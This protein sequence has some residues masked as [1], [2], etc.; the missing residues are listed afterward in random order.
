MKKWYIYEIFNK[1]KDL[2]A[3]TT[4]K[5]LKKPYSYSLAI[6]TGEKVD[7]IELNRKEFY[8]HFPS[9]YKIYTL[10]QIH[11]AKVI[12]VD[13]ITFNEYWNKKLIEADAMVTSQKKIVLSIL[14]ADCTALLAYD[15]I[16]KVIGATHAGWRGT[17]ENIAKNMIDLM[18]KK[19]ANIENIKVAISPSI[20]ACC[21]EVGEEVAKNFF[22]FS[23]A[24]VK[25]GE[26]K[27]HLDIS[28]VNKE[29]LLNIGIKEDNLEVS[30]YCTS[31]SNE[32][33]FSYRKEKGCSGRFINF[34]AMK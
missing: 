24:L 2:I 21:Y 14:T 13:H 22:N 25:T 23:D 27:W 4:I 17:K 3:G 9:D 28:I 18:V 29:Q 10:S 31:C 16:A 20:R 8:S 19:G 26:K 30:K 1:E 11:S 5:D 33:Y 12:D 32:L 7:L 34:I 6:H 15:N